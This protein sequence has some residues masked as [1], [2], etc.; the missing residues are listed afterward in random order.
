MAPEVV[1]RQPHTTASDIWSFGGILYEMLTGTM[2]FG[3]YESKV[4]L[5]ELARGTLGISWPAI[6]YP[7]GSQGL[8]ERCMAYD[9]AERPSAALARS[10]KFIS[11]TILPQPPVQ[12]ATKVTRY[13]EVRQNRQ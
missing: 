7:D 3:Q 11:E 2:A 9:P 4:L 10:H 12:M 13:L 8:V 6:P 1:N 5:E